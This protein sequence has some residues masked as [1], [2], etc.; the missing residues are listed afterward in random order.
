MFIWNSRCK[1]AE[2]PSVIVSRTGLSNIPVGH[3]VGPPG[4]TRW[5]TWRCWVLFNTCSHLT[6]S[7]GYL[8]VFGDGVPDSNPPRVAGGNQLVTN[9]EESLCWDVQAE[10]AFRETTHLG[11]SPPSDFKCS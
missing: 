5:H 1:D 3:S 11:K 4:L 2:R 10:D 6:G 7:S 9:E 8:P